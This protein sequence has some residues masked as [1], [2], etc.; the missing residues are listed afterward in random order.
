VDRSIRLATEEGCHAPP[1]GDL[2]D[3][4]VAHRDSGSAYAPISSIHL[5]DYR[6]V[7]TDRNGRVVRETPVAR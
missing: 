7:Y 4:F 5:V 1:W 2:A 3:D 6:L